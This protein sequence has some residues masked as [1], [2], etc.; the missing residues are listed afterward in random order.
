MGQLH[1]SYFA[2]VVVTNGNEMCLDRQSNKE[3]GM[4]E[5]H[6]VET[7]LLNAL[8]QMF[9]PERR[10][11]Y[12]SSIIEQVCFSTYLFP[13]TYLCFPVFQARNNDNAVEVENVHAMCFC[14]MWNLH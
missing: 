14:I 9:S 3:E 2:S 13:S 8:L 4:K 1:A 7:D 11:V 5:W 12:L 6:Q 10:D